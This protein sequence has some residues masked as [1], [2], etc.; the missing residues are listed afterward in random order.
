MSLNCDPNLRVCPNTT[1]PNQA[2]RAAEASLAVKGSKLFNIL[3]I[4][5]RNITSD[6]TE[7]FKNALD[8][9][10]GTIPDEPTSQDEGRSAETNSLLHQIPM[11][12]QQ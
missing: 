6:K 5:I 8:R 4:E 11:S 12:R 2:K 10:L 1:A 9:Y 3:P 7:V